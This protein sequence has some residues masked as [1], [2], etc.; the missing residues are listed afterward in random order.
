MPRVLFLSQ[1]YYPA[2]K[3]WIITIIIAVVVVISAFSSRSSKSHVSFR[4]LL[5]SLQWRFWTHQ[6]S[7]I[8][9]CIFSHSF[10]IV[11]STVTRQAYVVDMAQ[12]K[13]KFKA[14]RP[15]GGKKPSQKPKGAKKGGKN[16][17]WQSL[18]WQFVQPECEDLHFYDTVGPPS[19]LYNSWSHRLE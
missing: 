7:T 18:E 13:Q 1:Y 15:G 2:S 19:W 6:T 11:H 9:Q 3:N 17:L 5:G 14:Q 8:P 10:S 12:G 16:A 4:P